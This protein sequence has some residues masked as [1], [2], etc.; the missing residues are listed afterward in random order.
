MYNS[1][2]L[3]IINSNYIRNFNISISISTLRRLIKKIL[4]SRKRQSLTPLERNTAEK[5]NARFVYATDILKISKDNLIFSYE[6]GFN[7]HKRRYY[8][9]SLINMKAYIV[10]S[11]NK[12]V[13]RVLCVL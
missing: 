1:L 10:I 13:N 12:S 9:Y 6:T 8:G 7:E 11:A 2:T 3:Y 4:F 5:T